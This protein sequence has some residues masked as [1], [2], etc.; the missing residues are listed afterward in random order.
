VA[1][2]RMS[3]V[4]SPPVPEVPRP[5]AAPVLMS[6]LFAPVVRP[7]SE[8]SLFPDRQVE[9]GGSIPRSG[10]VVTKFACMFRVAAPPRGHNARDQASPGE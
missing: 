10:S 1:G 9:A 7:Y 4:A 2:N 5:G 3:N 8:S 6:F